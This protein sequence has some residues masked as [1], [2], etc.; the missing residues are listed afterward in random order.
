MTL[1]AA[2]PRL[3]AFLG[4]ESDEA[5][6]AALAAVFDDSTERLLMDCVRRGLFG[7]VH[8]VADAEDVA[9]ETR[10][11]LI[12]RLRALRLDGGEVIEDFAAY[13]ATTATRTCYAHLRARFPARTRFRNQVRYSVARHADTMLEESGGVW[14]CRSRALRLAASRSDVARPGQGPRL[15]PSRGAV[16]QFVEAPRAF[17]SQA[18]IDPSAP[19]PQVIASILARLDAPIELD[20]LVDA[21][22]LVLGIVEVRAVSAGDPSGSQVLES[23]PDQSPGTLRTMSDREELEALWREVIEL[24]P[25][26]RIA[27]L[28][29]LRDPDGGAALHALPVTGLVTRAELARLLEL[30]EAALSTLWDR[31]PLDDLSIGARLGM[32]RQQVIN[33]RKAARA[34]LARRT[35]RP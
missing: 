17:L 5:A 12:R 10:V 11:R 19:L 29:N 35:E 15:V 22:A 30:D 3:A 25:N 18:R 2:D 4:A 24:P 9:S 34:R 23:V 21:L 13:V 33:L 8:G 28:L 27:L 20:R 14:R 26:Q 1:D 6:E 16:Q 32:T 31:L 7:S